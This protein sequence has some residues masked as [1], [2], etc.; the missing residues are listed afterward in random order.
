MKPKN[1]L[2]IY[3]A[4]VGWNHESIIPKLDEPWKSTNESKVPLDLIWI[5]TI[6]QS[7][8]QKFMNGCQA[9]CIITKLQI[10]NMDCDYENL[11]WIKKMWQKCSIMF[12]ICRNIWSK[13]P[14]S[15]S[16]QVLN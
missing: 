8:L 16:C 3:Q 14:K 6:V 11:K 9:P 5:K 2:W 13:W 4:Q 15:L 12:W 1:S 10:L 7:K